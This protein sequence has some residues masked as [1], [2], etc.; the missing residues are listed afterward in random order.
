[1]PNGKS[2]KD[3]ILKA[4]HAQNL[5]DATQLA[6]LAQQ[7]QQE[8]E[9]DDRYV[10][11]LATLKKT[12]DIE[13]LVKKIRSRMRHESLLAGGAV[14]AQPTCPC[15][16]AGSRGRTRHRGA[17][18][19][20]GG[21]VAGWSD[22]VGWKV[23]APG[24]YPPNVTIDARV[25]AVAL[26]VQ[27]A[28]DGAVDAAHIYVAG[29]GG[30]AA[31][32]FNTISRCPI[33]GPPASPWDAPLA[34]V[35][36]DRLF[37]ANFADAPVLWVGGGEGDA[38]LADKLKAAGINMEWREPAGL[39]NGVVFEWL[40]NV[41]A[42]RRGGTGP[43]HAGHDRRPAG[44]LATH[45]PVSGAYLPVRRRYRTRARRSA[46]VPATTPRRSFPPAFTAYAR[47]PPAIRRRNCT[48]SICASPHASNS[49]FGCVRFPTSGKAAVSQRLLPDTETLVRYF[50]PDVDGS[51]S[52]SFEAP[53]TVNGGLGRPIPGGGPR[54]AHR[55][56]T[57]RTRRVRGAGTLSR[58]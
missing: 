10:L 4:E 17:G 35:T 29:R 36:T 16:C 31:A 56:S 57:G 11:S 44:G 5:K 40:L 38:A 25:Q 58:A 55:T 6:E 8:L 23:I 51:R 45:Q 42:R 49:F 46:D 15:P 52:G 18:S 48:K 22:Q 12:E 1:M 47:P 34:A 13:K 30:A 21:T 32:V 19:G 14:R 54:L 39:T 9:R 2:Q 27:Q 41:C 37:A 26:A 53:R 28:K 7:L 3:E 43:D 20:R 24:P 50:G 33:F